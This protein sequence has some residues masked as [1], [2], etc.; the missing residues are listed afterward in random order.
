MLLELEY[1]RALGLMGFLTTPTPFDESD[2]STWNMNNLSREGLHRSIN[3]NTGTVIYKYHLREYHGQEEYPSLH[4]VV[5]NS[6]TCRSL[7]VD[8]NPLMR[9]V[10]ENGTMVASVPPCKSF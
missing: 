5:H 7:I 8:R 4:K 9:N 1:M 10:Y 6:S 2:P 3:E